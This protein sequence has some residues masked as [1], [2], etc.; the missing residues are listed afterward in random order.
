ME[1][2]SG[3]FSSIV[4]SSL[5]SECGIVDRRHKIKSLPRCF[6]GMNFTQHSSK[7][8][9]PTAVAAETA[10]TEEMKPLESQVYICSIWRE[11]EQPT[12]ICPRVLSS[13]QMKFYFLPFWGFETFSIW[14]YL[15]QVHSQASQNHETRALGTIRVMRLKCQG[16]FLAQY[17][18]HF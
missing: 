11:T 9:R 16:S 17:L 12:C 14:A 5:L 1:R 10:F 13:S 18:K 4:G 8:L 3:V 15:T 2:L 6:L 7:S